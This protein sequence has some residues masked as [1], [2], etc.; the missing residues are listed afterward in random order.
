MMEIAI[1]ITNEKLEREQ[2][3]G[4]SN[5]PNRKN[6]HQMMEL[7]LNG[8]AYS[9]TEQRTKKKNTNSVEK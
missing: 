4:K 8:S 9:A 5:H 3:S 6:L 2:K 7:N 1:K